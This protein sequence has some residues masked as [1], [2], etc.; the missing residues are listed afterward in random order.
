MGWGSARICG[1]I[2]RV[3]ASDLTSA[4]GVNI[5]SIFIRICCSIYIRI[6]LID[7]ALV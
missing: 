4:S 2:S 6:L 1:K 3:R 7:D 5:V